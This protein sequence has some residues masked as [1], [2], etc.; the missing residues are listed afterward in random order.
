MELERLLRTLCGRAPWLAAARILLVSAGFTIHRGATE[1]IS[2]A[3]REPSDATR[4]ARLDAL[5]REHLVGGEKLIR[6][7]KVSPSERSR[8]L[9][10][11]HAKRKGNTPLVSAFPGVADEAVI[12]T[13]ANT[14]ASSAG[15]V[16]LENG[17]AAVFTSVRSYLDRISIPASKLKP[18]EAEGYEE[19][20][21]LQR[22]FVQTYDA[23][24]LPSEGDFVCLAAD[25]PYT[26]PS[27]FAR[28]SQTELEVQL[29]RVLGRSL[30]MLNLWPAVDGLYK[31]G[32]GRLVDYGFVNNTDAV[33]HHTA[34][35]GGKSLRD[36]IYDQAGAAAVG[37]DLIPFKLAVAWARGGTASVKAQPELLLPGTSAHVQTAN[38]RLEH[39]IV[40]NGLNSRDLD[41]VISRLLPF[42]K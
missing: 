22:K 26:A 25:L 3:L 5:L 28:E 36:D 12:R 21:A 9:D 24:W 8:V 38:A 42:A 18:G 15:H 17:V 2:A 1:T 4:L 34:R 41:F 37:D 29:R 32:E 19:I 11:I 27:G 40:R 14:E 20:F 35:R 16:Q 10:W 6:L 7:V 30:T 31:A 33:K 23:V 39:A 13:A